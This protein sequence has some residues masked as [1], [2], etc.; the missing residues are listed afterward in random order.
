[1]DKKTLDVLLVSVVRS[2]DP[3][4]VAALADAL[5][6]ASA[7]DRMKA[8]RDLV[9]HANNNVKVLWSNRS[10]PVRFVNQRIVPHPDRLNDPAYVEYMRQ[11]LRDETLHYLGEAIDLNKWY[12]LR[13][14]ECLTNDYDTIGLYSMNTRRLTL[15]AEV[16]SLDGGNIKREKS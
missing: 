15:R 8:I 5:L 3:A 13:M 14:E 10:E 6:D 7:E 9:H 12:A 11:P 1:M 2:A 16:V 4:D